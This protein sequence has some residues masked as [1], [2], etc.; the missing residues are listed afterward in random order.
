MYMGLKDTCFTEKICQHEMGHIMGLCHTQAR[1]DRDDNVW[2][3][4][5]NMN[6]S[7]LSKE[8]KQQFYLNETVVVSF[9]SPTPRFTPGLSRW[10]TLY[11]Y[12]DV[13]DCTSQYDKSTALAYG[14][15]DC[16]GNMHYGSTACS[17]NGQPVMVCKDSTVSPDQMGSAPTLTTEEFSQIKQICGCR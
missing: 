16:R 17:I 6:A 8:E 11:F 10:L 12:L 4:W 14:K 9:V 2:I 5:E 15:Y 3:Y 7:K 13:S 1:S